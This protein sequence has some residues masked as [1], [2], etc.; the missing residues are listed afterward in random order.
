MAPDLATELANAL[1]QDEEELE[2]DNAFAL[3]DNVPP[4]RSAGRHVTPTCLGGV[5]EHQR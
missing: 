2:G 4:A 1:A 5:W 3:V